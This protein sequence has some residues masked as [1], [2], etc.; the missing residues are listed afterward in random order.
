MNVWQRNSN[1]LSFE[2]HIPKK[3]IELFKDYLCHRFRE[4]YSQADNFILPD[5]W[6][7]INNILVLKFKDKQR[8]KIVKLDEIE[9]Y[10]KD[11]DLDIEDFVKAIRTLALQHKLNIAGFSQF[12]PIK[13]KWVVPISFFT[14][15]HQK[16]RLEE[17]LQQDFRLVDKWISLIL[18]AISKKSDKETIGLFKLM[19]EAV[20]NQDYSEILDLTKNFKIKENPSFL[21]LLT[22][23]EFFHKIRQIY[24]FKKMSLSDAPFKNI[25]KNEEVLEIDLYFKDYHFGKIKRPSVQ[26]LWDDLMENNHITRLLVYS[27]LK[28]PPNPLKILRNH[29]KVVEWIDLHRDQQIIVVK[30]RGKPFPQSG[31]LYVYEFGD[32]DQIQKKRKFINF[33]KNHPLLEKYLDSVPIGE[34]GDFTNKYKRRDLAE[35]ICNNQGLFIVQGPPGTG[36]TYL[37]AEVVA[38]FLKTNIYAKILVCSKEH[39]AL[40]YIL[41]KVMERLNKEN[42][43]FRAFR[44]L[45]YIKQRTSP[46]ESYIKEFLSSSVMR[47]IGSYKWKNGSKIWYHAQESLVQE[48]DLRNLSLAI[49][50][51][52]I[53]FCTTM[54]GIFHQLINKKS[55][56]L[57]IVEE[58]GKSYPSELLHTICLG[59]RTLLIGDQNQLPPYQ[60]R[61]TEEALKLWEMTLQNIKS[62]PNLDED[63]Q[64]RF[65]YD[66]FKLKNFYNKNSSFDK[67]QLC[68]LKPFETLFNLLPKEKK[69]VLDQ[70]YRMERSLSNIIGRVFYNREFKHKKKIEEPLIGV[71]PKEYNVPLLWIDTP[72]MTEYMDA[73]EDPEKIGKRVNFYE[74][75]VLITYLNLLKPIKSIDFIILTPYNDQKDLFLESEELKNV[76]SKLTIQPFKEIIKTTDEYQG[77]EADLT[78]LSLVRNNTLYAAS[79]WG[80]I[81]EPER[82]NVMFSRTKSRQVI[83]GCAQHIIRNS[84]EERIKIFHNLYLEY[85]KEGLFLSSEKFLENQEKENECGINE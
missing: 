32:I 53:I 49:S 73:T 67:Q 26:E 20:N 9:K 17:A 77:H 23:S 31:F 4:L 33:V 50:S 65:G 16:Q 75:S 63:L 36:K 70:Q 59:Q 25:R 69:Y 18:I 56:D 30:T 83:V 41:K 78:I 46:I 14:R 39:L 66:Y 55:F 58:A 21:D 84:H 22:E 60:I 1:Q 7:F 62:D 35:I 5:N 11:L 3:S 8:L 51:A 47:E 12:L 80:F 72:H 38:K 68:W 15:S 57:V 48:Y 10:S 82:L 13:G 52:S 61:K 28:T 76:C 2:L 42:L 19:K 43:E 54:D 24:K 40:N 34:S 44:S 85:K 74:L 79:S 27:N 81:I 6:L 29:E 71:I 64:K 37:A 45:S